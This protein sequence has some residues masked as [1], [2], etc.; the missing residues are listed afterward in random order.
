MLGSQLSP[1]TKSAAVHHLVRQMD[2]KTSELLERYQSV[3]SETEILVQPLEV[4]DMVLQSM[5]DASPAKWHLAHTS[6]F[7]ETFVL[8]VLKPGY[9]VFDPSYAYL[10]NSYYEAAGPRHPRP[11]R[12]LISRP[13]VDS[14]MSY[15]QHV[16]DHMLDFLQGTPFDEARTIIELGLAHEQQHQE[17]L[18]M[19]ILHLFAQSPMRPAYDRS[20]RFKMKA[21]RQSTFKALGGGLVTLGM[22]ETGFAYDNE[23][24]AHRVWIEPFEIADRLVTAGEWLDFMNA[25]GY[26][27]PQW[28]LSDGWALVQAHHWHAPLYWEFD[29]QEWR[30]MTLQGMRLVDVASPVTHVSYY[31]AAAYARWKGARLPTEAEWEHAAREGKLEQMYDIAW[32]W[33]RSSY[34]AYPGYEPAADALGEY[35]GKFMSNQMVLRGASLATPPDHVRP[36]YRNFYRPEQRWMFSGV[37]LA[38]DVAAH[39]RTLNNENEFARDVVAGLSGSAKTISP[40]YF[41]DAVGSELFEQICAT[42]E[43]YP[44]RTELALLTKVAPALALAAPKG[45]ALVE[46]GSGASEKTRLLLDAAP[47]LGTYIPVDISA[48]A[49]E[50]ALHRLQASYPHLDI[51]PLIADFTQPLAL[52]EAIRRG[53]VVGFFPG[54]TIGNFEPFDATRLLHKLRTELGSDSQLIVGVDLVKDLPT[55]L[56]AYN[57]AGG[58]TANFNKNLLM[59]FNQELEADIELDSFEHRSIWNADKR[60]IEMHLVS[61]IDQSVTVAG[62]RFHFTEGESI[63]TENSH[64]F[65][66]DSFAAL[67]EGTGWHIAQSWTSDIQPFGVFQLVAT[68]A[69]GSR[70]P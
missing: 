63:H 23:G 7:F 37:R 45:A 9:R 44:T 28:W 29:G 36:S 49:L 65:T 24:P 59:R 40:K 18:L 22:Q 20:G 33:T 21:V 39:R 54:S 16:D 60:R 43:Y 12:G 50:Q 51:Q 53:P 13:T 25:G 19:D 3:R 5:P 14:I 2:R 61:R 68:P 27:Q 8:S 64:K 62:K 17:L 66:P 35:N 6:W 47:Q 46:L 30:H 48:D 56:A 31:E 42:P 10:F 4:E 41:Y 11:Q 26:E 67:V 32:Q 55:L 15:R 69:A 58:V 52:P 70:R 57:D 1:H 38:R 34:D